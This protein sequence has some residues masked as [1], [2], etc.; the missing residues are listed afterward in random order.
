MNKLEFITTGNEILS[1]IT[2][3]TNFSWAAEQFSLN[4]LIPSYHCSIG[5]DVQDIEAAFSIAVDRSAFVIVTGGLGPTDD[6]LTAVTAA[7]FFGVDLVF[8]ET[9]YA[10]IEE[11]I[12]ERRRKIL[13]IH[14]KQALFPEGSEIIKNS[15]GTSNGFKFI[16]KESFFYFLP[17]VPREFKTMIKDFVLPDVLKTAG[18]DIYVVQKV[19]KTIGLGESEVALKLKDLKIDN[20]DFSYRI[21]YPEIHLKLVARNSSLDGVNKIINH[22]THSIKQKLGSFIFTDEDILMEQVIADLLKINNLTIST[23]ESCT[24]GLLGNLLTDIPGSSDYFLRGVISYSN[25]SKSELL[26]VDAD[27]FDTVGSVSKEVVEQ[28]A[29]GIRKISSTDIGIGISGIAGPG[30]GSKEKPVGTV[31]IGVDYMNSVY[32]YRYN[33]HGTRKDIKLSSAKY[34]LDIVR[35]LIIKNNKN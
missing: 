4:G 32:S 25:E 28:M 21:K 19:I 5:D 34:A 12:R 23:A 14:K 33:F 16:Y 27:L 18:S 7:D 17:G 2:V 15:T 1:G 11:K 8:D 31:Y 35:K 20:A 6:D 9:S 24:G 30:G 29:T 3:D 26:G 13:V 22:H 10:E